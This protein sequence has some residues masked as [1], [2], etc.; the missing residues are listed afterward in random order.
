MWIKNI[1]N[2]N[3]QYVTQILQ[4]NEKQI[5]EDREKTQVTNLTYFYRKDICYRYLR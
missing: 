3:M 4:D 1:F 5:F 2:Q